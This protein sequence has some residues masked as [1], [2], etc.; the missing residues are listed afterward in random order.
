MSLNVS[1]AQRKHEET[2]YAERTQLLNQIHKNFVPPHSVFADKGVKSAKEAMLRRVR[3]IER[4]LGIQGIP[5]NSSAF[6][7]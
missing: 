1:E 4:E 3:E 5:Y 7:G 2:L 6:G